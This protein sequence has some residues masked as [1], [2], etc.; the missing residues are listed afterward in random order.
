ML[1]PPN[2]VTTGAAVIKASV[3]LAAFIWIS[4]AIGRVILRWLDVPGEDLE[5]ERGIAALGLGVG[6]VQLVPLTLGAAGVLTLWPLRIATVVLALALIP[7]LIAVGRQLLGFVR[8]RLRPE[9]WVVAGLLAL[10][11]G[12]VVVFLLAVTPAIDPDGLGYHLT[13]P[14]RWLAM[15]TLG[16]LPTYTNSNMPMGVEMLFT[17]GMAFAG[18]TG[19]KL[20]HFALGLFGAMGLYLSGRHLQRPGVGAV[21]AVLF[22]FGPIGVSGLLGWAYLEGAVGFAVIASTLAWLVWFRGR[23]R[24]WLRTAFALAGVAVSFK[25]T[26]GLFP[27]SLLVLTWLIECHDARLQDQ[28]PLSP[29]VRSW[30]LIVLMGVPLAPWLFRAAIV[31]GNPVFPMFAAW[32]P[33]RDFSAPLAAQ[34]EVFNR[35]LNWATRAGASWTLEQRKLVLAGVALA[36]TLVSGVVFRF[37]RSWEARATL[38]AVLGTILVQ[39]AAVGLYT[40]YWIPLAAVLQLPILALCASAIPAG[41]WQRPAIVMLTAA[42]SLAGARNALKSVDNDVSGLVLTALGIQPQQ[43]FLRRHLPLYAIHQ[44]ANSELPADS[45]ILLDGYCG[46]FHVDRRTFCLDIVQGSISTESW[47]AFTA[48]ARRLGVTHVLA[49][50]SLATGRVEPTPLLASAG[51]GS[52]VREHT[53]MLLARLL[54]AHARILVSADDQGLYVIEPN[55]LR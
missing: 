8:G 41:A 36:F 29:I 10:V 18:D 2:L 4:L 7:E 39:I 50:R 47:D 1:S 13:V 45:G 33:S 43:D 37:L 35:Y 11:P 49:P 42:L 3:F 40:R 16:Y 15:G 25:I 27:L 48:D 9:A 51:V 26:A 31:T 28:S 52:M 12:L 22:L 23:R 21:A 32:I 54:S 5:R 19:A 20:I 34:W 44:Y 46:G 55:A 30:P 6:A 38:L 53:D 24:G 17:I 14:K